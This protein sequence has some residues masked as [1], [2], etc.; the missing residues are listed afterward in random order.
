MLNVHENA[1]WLNPIPE[2]YWNRI[3]SASIIQQIFAD[4]MFP[5]TIEGIDKAMREL[6]K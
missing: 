6:N 4:R 3:T 2:R 5:L 1:V